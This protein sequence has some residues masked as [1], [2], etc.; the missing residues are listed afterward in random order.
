MCLRYPVDVII[1][2]DKDENCCE[3]FQKNV[4][5]GRDDCPW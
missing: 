5:G 4:Q 2:A 1:S 3:K